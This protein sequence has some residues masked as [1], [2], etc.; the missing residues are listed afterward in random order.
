VAVGD[1]VDEV[2]DVLPERHR[3]IIA[4]PPGSIAALR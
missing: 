3:S 2:A 1:A 4:A